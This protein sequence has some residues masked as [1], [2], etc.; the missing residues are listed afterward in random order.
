MS[1][2]YKDLKQECYEANMQLNALNLV[3]YTFGNVSAVD[4]KN[5]V[6]A[7]KPS[8]VPYEDLKPEDIVIVDFD[9]NIIEGTMRPSSDTKTH[10]YLYKNWPNIGGVAHTHATYSVAWAQAQ[11]DIPIFG[12]THADHLTADIPC[13]PPMADALI[14]G[15]YEHNTGI[16]ILDCFKE[17][18]LSYEEVEMVL[19]GNH[20]P[21][22]WGKNAAKAVYN[23]KV[24][25][26]VAEMAY[27]T[28]QINP[29]APRLKDSLIKKHYNRKHGK[30]SYYGQ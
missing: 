28:L 2:L 21:F 9:N 15:N 6:F 12:T 14:E 27:L 16:Q 3:V 30:D 5:G 20:G 24:L 11:Q 18:N 25:E 19:I 29:N 13:A 10:A 7:I 23:S 26:V 4:R 8:G 22:A 17:K 1:S